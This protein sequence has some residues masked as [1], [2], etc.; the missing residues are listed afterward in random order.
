[1][2]SK[3]KI[4]AFAFLLSSTLITAQTNSNI[5]F[6][7]GF[8]GAIVEGNTYTNPSGSES[9]AGF[10]NEDV[11]LYPISFAEIGEI[12]F[13]GSS[14]G[15]DVNI[16]FKFEFN[17]YPDTEPS[18]STT[19]LTIS[20]SEET[21]YSVSIPAQGNDTFSSFLLYVNTPDVP[22]TIANVTLSSSE[23]IDPCAL[24]LCTDGEVCVNG[25]CIDYGG[26]SVAA[27][28]PQERDPEDVISFYSEAYDDISID[29]FDF[30]LCSNSGSNE[31]IIAGDAVQHYYG[32]GCQGILF[33]NNRV[34]ASEFTTVHFDFYTNEID[35]I[36]K[37]FNLKFVDWAGNVDA[38]TSTG[39]EVNFNGGTN[40]SMSSGSWISVD[41]DI[42]SVGSMVAG[43][44]TRSDIA[45]IH[46]TSNLQNAWYDNVYLHKETFVPG[47]CTDGILNQNETDIDCGGVCEPCEEFVPGT[48]SDGILNQD[49]TEIDCGGV[50]E[51][52]FI[53]PPI[54]PAPNPP[55]RDP[56]NVISIYS[57]AYANVTIDN[58]D[59]GLCGSSAVNE[60][61]ILGNGMQRYAGSGCQ[62]ISFEN[63]RINAAAFTNLHFDFYTDETNLIGKVFNIK[64]VDWAGNATEAGSTGLEINFNDGTNP[65]ITAGSWISVDVD[66]SSF[67]PMVSGN[68]TRSDIAHIHITSNLANAWYDNLY[69]YRD[70]LLPGT[71]YDGIQN[72]DETGI[73]CGGAFC[74][75]CIEIVSGCIDPSASNYDANATIQSYNQYGNSSCVYVSCDSV[76]EPGC[77]YADGFDPFNQEFGP[78]ECEGYGGTS[79]TESSDIS[80]EEKKKDTLLAYPNPSKDYLVV[81]SPLLLNVDA[82]LFLHDFVGHLVLHSNSNDAELDNQILD[83]SDLSEGIYI[84]SISSGTER[85]N[86]MILKY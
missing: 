34:D 13:V 36:G 21:T 74:D 76:P 25:N 2:N 66:I 63:N 8:G 82:Q 23:I 84:L 4:I 44:L 70:G 20:G 85:L 31:E 27:P 1:M 9:W 14:S 52:C 64:L 50:C 71:C 59:F 7:G 40:P 16:S 60:E 45:E 30:G 39:L 26:P 79:C 24:V 18:F 53:G 68:L 35:L 38:S 61:F 37:V 83:L 78:E 15:A 80:I 48:C 75:P 67:G 6:S 49:E 77:I 11:A 46:I 22:V 65:N 51:P 56:E 62:G 3:L 69:I 58:F 5:V 47:T 10:A 19:S 73:D 12:S 81:T 32:P 33:N 28:T 41:V 54:S 57:D 86:E 29:N 72:Q 17:P 42:S 43:N 55:A